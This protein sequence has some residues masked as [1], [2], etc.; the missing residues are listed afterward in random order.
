MDIHVRW[1]DSVSRELRKV[2]KSQT[3]D[4]LV[5]VPGHAATD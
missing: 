2:L 4:L 3:V 5:L 1:G